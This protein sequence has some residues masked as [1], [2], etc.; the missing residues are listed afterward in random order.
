M[1]L[2]APAVR[3]H[4]KSFT[5]KPLFIEELGW[6]RFNIQPVPIE[7]AGHTY[8]LLPVAQKRGAQIF[9]CQP[10]PDGRLP[11]YP[12]RQRIDRELTRFA[13]EHLIIFT[14]AAH[15]TQVW[16]WVNREQGK[17]AAYREETYRV[18]QSGEQLIQHLQS[19][20]FSL[21]EE[22]GLSIS[23][24]TVRLKDAFDRERVTRRFYDR[25][26]TEHAAFLGFIS[27][28][29]SQADRE[30]YASLMLNRL[31]FIYFIQKKGFLD[32]D[33]DYLPNRL[34]RLRSQHTSDKFY[35]FYRYFLLRLFHEGLGSSSRTPDLDALLGRVPYLNGGLFEMHQL[36]SDNPTIAIPDRAFEQIFAFFD[37]YNWHLDDRPLGS[38]REINPDVLG[39]I[40]EKY[41]N[42]KQMGAYY[43][44]E[45]ITGYITQ[46]TVIP[47]LFDAAR[48]NV[49]IAFEGD[50][51]SV[52][53]LLQ[54]DPDRYIYDAVKKG[55]HLPL[56]DDIAAGLNDVSRR[57]G[58]NRPAPE[59]YALPI[60]IWRE[61]VT[62]RKRYEVVRANLEAGEVR[63][64]NDLITLNLDI[65][66]FA[67]D[68]IQTAEGP[69][70]LRAFWKA[71]N[72]ITIL[73]PTCGSGA[74]LFAALNILKPLY[75]A[76]LNRM[77]VFLDDLER[78]TAPH[79][80]ALFS[81]FR[82][83][84]DRVAA[85]PNRDY[86]ILKSIIL[87]NLYGVD[88][89]EEAVEIC[90]LRLFLK[91]VAQLDSPDHVEPLPDIDFNIR[92]GNT[93][94]GFATYADVQRIFVTKMDLDNAQGR[95][96][97]SAE[98]AA[99]KFAMFHRQQTELGGTVTAQDKAALRASLKALNDELDRYLAIEYSI[100][101][102]D[103]P[104]FDKWRAFHQPF[105]WF[106][107]FYG[108]MD[109]GGF[110]VIIGN[111][112]YVEYSKIKG[113]YTIRHY[114]TEESGNLYAFVMERTTFL[115]N[116]V[117]TFSMIVPVASI[118]SERA[119]PLRALL[120]A[121]FALLISSFDTKP[122]RLFEVD[123]RLAIWIASSRTVG[124]LLTTGYLHWRKEEREALFDRLQYAPSMSRTGIPG[125]AKVP[126]VLGSH[127]LS[128]LMSDV[129]SVALESMR[130]RTPTPWYIFYQ[131][132][133]RYWVKSALGLPYY[134]KNGIAQAPSHGR[135]VYCP[136]QAMAAALF[137]ALNSSL[138][139][140]YFSSWSDGFHV[141]EYVVSTLPVVRVQLENSKLAELGNSL[142]S[143]LKRT[144]IKRDMSTNQGYSLRYDEY[145]QAL[146]KPVI[147]EI[148][149]VLAEHYGFTDEELDFIVNYDIKYRM[150]R[151]SEEGDEE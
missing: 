22:E 95:I 9:Q 13:R 119:A 59:D 21:S 130:R 131:E 114:A 43:T 75:E 85:H 137:A 143:A 112:P 97:E 6:D 148:D 109:R 142:D 151:D 139:Y 14:D 77:Q 24:V 65:R 113:Q 108:I 135:Y 133:A 83:V 69:E 91:L 149:R 26:K 79:H 88:I 86:F 93:L 62:R 107:E 99:R 72:A 61:V 120:A 129:S 27:G 81:D 25:F 116:K 134:E 74:F 18:N 146:V 52:W 71:I 87:N 122:S 150:G 98:I 7:A 78:S 58:W 29:T 11:D 32:G 12:T 106:T 138:Y 147:D 33:P 60:E 46:N 145:Q 66:Q 123:Q 89:M 37:E 51:P 144:A 53:R 94:V 48:P 103:K 5:F 57:T 102:H 10:D 76:C 54:A 4:L 128:K 70:I 80:P 125:W 73:D 136:D 90:K 50:D 55:T 49:R 104:A 2:D 140:I 23:G 100:D 96:K 34:E 45:D 15:T 111:P 117:G 19:I 63:D 141:S 20:V 16:Q 42:Q 17:P 126:T 105:H 1:P 132:A 64:I 68:V 41:I 115:L 127:I 92:A 35:S 101:P 8:T 82:E 84:L 40:F 3:R 28:I 67:L 36:E 118:C 124:N 56:P 38:A 121:R 44:R 30:W 31:M 39:Y 110:D 47:Y